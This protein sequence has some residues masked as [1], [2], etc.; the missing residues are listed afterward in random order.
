MLDEGRPV[1]TI[2][3][4]AE[5]LGVHPRTL[6]LYEDGGLIRPARKNNRRFYSTS[7][8][9]WIS[10]IRYLI[11]EKGLNQEGLRRLLA[12]I[13]CWEM[14]GCSDQDQASCIACS[15]RSAPC[16]DWARRDSNGANGRCYAC[17]VYL[18][19]ANHVL[20]EAEREEAV[21]YAWV[22]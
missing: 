19:A 5:I 18:S 8:L 2:G 21:Q 10:C 12:L 9:Q 15:D 4:A 7:D 3:T 14:R 6:R 1:Y 13:P 16:W 17:E 22:S 20:D 11:H